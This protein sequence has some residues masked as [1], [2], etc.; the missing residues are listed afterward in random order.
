MYIVWL[1]WFTDSIARWRRQEERLYQLDEF[2]VSNSSAPTVS[3]PPSDP[4]AISSDTD[5][6]G[7]ID[8]QDAD[9]LERESK[10]DIPISAE[11]TDVNAENF[12][13]G[14]VDWQNVHDE[15]EAAMMESDSD[16]EQSTASGRTS[17]NVSDEEGSET[18]ET[19]IVMGYEALFAASYAR[20]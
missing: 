1:S 9:S 19:S 16:E 18:E 10:E 7:T 17:G 20:D 2:S 12:D 3:S 13:M 15:V 14:G 6:E 8:D 5:P 4:T 11:M